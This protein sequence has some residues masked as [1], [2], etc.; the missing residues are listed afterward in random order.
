MFARA[1]WS[2][3]AFSR[4]RRYSRQT[5]KEEV[6]FEENVDSLVGRAKQGVRAEDQE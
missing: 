1:F 2:S 3:L 6:T 5:R 4:W